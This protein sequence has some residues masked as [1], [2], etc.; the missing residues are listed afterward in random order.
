MKLS[1]ANTYW[2]KF[3]GCPF[4]SDL[5][6]GTLGMNVVSKGRHT[7]MKTEAQGKIE[8]HA[9]TA[10]PGKQKR[11]TTTAR[12]KGQKEALVRLVRGL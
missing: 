11:Q 4:P 1:E 6:D 8:E 7:Q 9:T 10:T 3:F 5:D 12:Q 2:N